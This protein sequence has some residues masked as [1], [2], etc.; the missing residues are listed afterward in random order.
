M[1]IFLKNLKT[2]NKEKKHIIYFSL[3]INSVLKINEISKA[4]STI[5]FYVIDVNNINCDISKYGVKETPY[6][7]FFENKKLILETNDTFKIIDFLKPNS[8]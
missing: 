7:M 1:F 5:N 4:L 8:F 6:F 3:G 2:I